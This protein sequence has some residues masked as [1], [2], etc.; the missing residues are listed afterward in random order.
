MNG[1]R[2][3]IRD[4]T[5]DKDSKRGSINDWSK[6]LKNSISSNKFIRTPKEKKIRIVL[7][8]ILK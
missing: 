8:K 2:S 4:G 6:S 5:I 3:K 7:I 1:N